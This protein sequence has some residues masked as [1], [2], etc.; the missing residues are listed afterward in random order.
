MT[1]TPRGYILG[2]GY[3]LGVFCT[4][5]GEIC[6]LRQD[7]EENVRTGKGS[8]GRQGRREKI[9]GKDREGNERR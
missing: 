1:N 5:F 2:F 9:L 7:K 8:K 6:V 4:G 3:P